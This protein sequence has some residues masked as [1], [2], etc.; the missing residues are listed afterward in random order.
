[1]RD[2]GRNYLFQFFLRLKGPSGT[3]STLKDGLGALY[4]LLWGELGS[5]DDTAIEGKFFACAA[6]ILVVVFAAGV[7]SRTL[8]A[9][10]S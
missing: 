5:A 1:M 7:A 6:A 2:N 10:F 4:R 8:L 9:C 3:S